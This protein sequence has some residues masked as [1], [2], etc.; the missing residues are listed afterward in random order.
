MC[1]RD[2]LGI[3]RLVAGGTVSAEEATRACLAR[4]DEREDD[5]GAWAHRDADY[6]LTQ[7]PMSVSYTLPRAHETGRTPVC[8]C[9]Q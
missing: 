7:A 8:R 2:R 4:I 3:A 9:R 6:A 5:I 1:V